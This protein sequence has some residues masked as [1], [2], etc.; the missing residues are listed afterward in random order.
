MGVPLSPA[1][2]LTSTHG[3]FKNCNSFTSMSVR[4]E[5]EYSQYHRFF[6]K[7]VSQFESGSFTSIT[8]EISN[9]LRRDA[10]TLWITV[11]PSLASA[12]SNR[13]GN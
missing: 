3:Q 13:W 9:P 2:Y 1:T 12:D 7:V 10:P 11:P 4:G 8:W 5:T 6:H